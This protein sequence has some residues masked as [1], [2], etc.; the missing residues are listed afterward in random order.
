MIARL[1]RKF[2]LLSMSAVVL[3]LAVLMGIVNLSNYA[4]V[5]A[6]AGEKL[7]LLSDNGGFFPGQAEDNP[8]PKP[9][10]EPSGRRHRPWYSKETPYETRYFTVELRESGALSSVNTGKIAAVSRE[11][12]ISMARQVQESGRTSGYLGS[13]RYLVC[14]TDGG[15]MYLFLDCTRDLESA[16]N[17]LRNSLLVSACGIAAV[18]LLVLLFSRRAVRPV[19]QSYERQKQFITNAGHEIKTPLTVINSCTQV[20]ELEQGENKWTEGIH[21]QVER[22]TELTA[23][24]VALARMDEH[25]QT[26]NR[27]T[28]CLSDVVAEAFAPFELLAQQR[29]LTMERTLQPEVYSSGDRRLL[30]Q[31]CTILADNAV[32]YSAPAGTIC[33]MLEQKGKKLVLRVSNPAGNLPQGSLAVLFYRF[34]RADASRSSETAGYGLGLSMA[35]SIVEAHG[36]RIEANR[37]GETTLEITVTLPG[38]TG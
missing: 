25:G 24:L 30:T 34:Y 33:V 23:S 21:T 26:L 9:E 4:R 29:G 19:A 20:L 3:V 6:M 18:F 7:Q 1:R 10:G 2:V 28:L 11:D 8:P 5:D 22:L 27:Q 37:L 38:K 15:A 14:Q 35:Q 12:A 13:Y 36:G 16:G 32:K 17:F 31:L